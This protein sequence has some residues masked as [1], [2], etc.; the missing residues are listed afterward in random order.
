MTC[1][2][3]PRHLKKE[4]MAFRA[5]FN[6]LKD[7][8]GVYDSLEDDIASSEKC[9]K[10]AQDKL[11]ALTGSTDYSTR[12]FDI[13]DIEDATVRYTNDLAYAKTQFQL[14]NE[15]CAGNVRSLIR[16]L[17]TRKEYEYEYWD[18]INVI[19]PLIPVDHS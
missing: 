10:N 2:G 3:M 9:L 13:K 19:D 8:W 14:F 5:L 17:K 7:S 18:F 1:V 6:Y 11:A 4:A 16:L 12:K 15:A